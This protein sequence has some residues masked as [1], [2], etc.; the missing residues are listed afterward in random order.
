MKYAFI[1]TR[2]NYETKKQVN[3]PRL[4]ALYRDN[5]TLIDVGWLCELDY[6]RFKEYAFLSIKLADL[7]IFTSD[8]NDYEE[9][10]KFHELSLE[11]NKKIEYED[12]LS[13]NAYLKKAKDNLTYFV[14]GNFLDQRNIPAAKEAATILLDYITELEEKLNTKSKIKSNNQLTLL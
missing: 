1:A 8:W 6:D 10:K 12:K 7:I 2:Y 4:A 13:A 5:Y 3:T 11:L 9:S 14:S